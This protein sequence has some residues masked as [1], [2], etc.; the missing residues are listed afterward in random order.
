MMWHLNFCV[1][2][3]KDKAGMVFSLVMKRQP[4][5]LA[6]KGYLVIFE[7][8]GVLPFVLSYH[9]H[10]VSSS[11]GEIGFAQQGTLRPVGCQARRVNILTCLGLR[12]YPGCRTF[13]ATTG[14]VPGKLGQLVTLLAGEQLSIF[15][16]FFTEC[17]DTYCHIW[18]IY[19]HVDTC[20]LPCIPPYTNIYKCIHINTHVTNTY[21]LY[22]LCVYIYT[23]TRIT[24]SI[25][26]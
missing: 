10:G 4:L 21:A 15:F 24:N 23:R 9:G 19:I 17:N 5:M 20:I 16:F 1:G 13:G 2:G 18:N 11:D 22:S 12:T 14:P 3:K 25:Y 26:I 8:H 6:S 7:L